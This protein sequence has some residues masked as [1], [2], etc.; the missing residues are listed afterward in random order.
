M[1]IMLGCLHLGFITG[2]V[3]ETL[4]KDII[5]HLVRLQYAM[6]WC[7]CYFDIKMHDIY[8]YIWDKQILVLFSDGRTVVMLKRKTPRKQEVPK[9]VKKMGLEVVG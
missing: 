3:R 1:T 5:N 7:I 9:G 2:K 8:I 4:E 6:G